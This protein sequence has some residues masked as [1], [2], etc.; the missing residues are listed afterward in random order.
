MKKILLDCGC[1]YGKGL[2][3]QIEINKIDSTWKIYCWEANPYTYDHF[4]KIDR[5]RHLDITA[6]HSAVSNEYGSI[7][8]NIQSSSAKNGGTNKSGT[9]SSV[10]SLNEWQCKGGEFIEKVQVPKIDLS[11]WM[12]KNLS[13]E[14]HVILKMDIEGAEYDV[15]EKIIEAG[16]LKFINRLYIEWHSHMFAV[17]DNYIKRQQII[18][19]EFKKKDI[20]IEVW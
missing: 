16:A 9:G 18:V 5:F 1:H 8:F 11:D 14:D 15:L 7:E 2:R 19:E 10:M 6:Y 3:K 4:L 20:L 12:I 17:P 13:E